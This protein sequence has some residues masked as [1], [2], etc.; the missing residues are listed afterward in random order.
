MAAKIEIYRLSDPPI[1]C[2]KPCA[3]EI[4][5]LVCGEP[6]QITLGAVSH[7]LVLGVTE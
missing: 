7:P 6:D 4:H 5:H 3:E 1:N 2:E